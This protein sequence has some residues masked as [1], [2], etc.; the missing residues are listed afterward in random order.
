VTM[1]SSSSQHKGATLI[2]NVPLQPAETGYV[3]K[4]PPVGNVEVLILVLFAK[5][6]LEQ[7]FRYAIHEDREKP[8][9]FPNFLFRDSPPGIRIGPWPGWHGIPK[10][11]PTVVS[12]GGRETRL[13]FQFWGDETQRDVIR[14]AARIGIIKNEDIV[15]RTSDSRLVP[16]EAQFYSVVPLKPAPF[17]LEIPDAVLQQRPRLLISESDLQS[18]RS[19]ALE[20]QEP[21]GRVAEL[22]HRW[23]QPQVITPESKD[24]KSVV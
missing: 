19:R 14:G 9:T 1:K 23:N 11:P 2:G 3:C 18:L 7:H 10:M 4:P 20:H 15:V 16:I 12:V 17:A 8:Y 21:F 13:E 24:R 5:Y 22:L 6:P